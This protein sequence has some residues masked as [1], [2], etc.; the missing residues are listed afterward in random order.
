MKRGLGKRFAYCCVL[1]GVA[2]GAPK[3]ACAQETPHAQYLAAAELVRQCAADNQVH[4]CDSALLALKG[5]THNQDYYF[6]EGSAYYHMFRLEQKSVFEDAVA[7]M[8]ESYFTPRRAFQNLT[9]TRANRMKKH[10]HLAI[11]NL[12]K[13][14]RKKSSKLMIIDLE[15]GLEEMD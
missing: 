15:D 6:I 12:L 5:A 2:L 11:N 4:L 13:V 10:A 7:S 1:V 14:K 3:V 9:D 8:G